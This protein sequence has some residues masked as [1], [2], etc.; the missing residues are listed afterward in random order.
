M[1]VSNR[2]DLASNART[3]LKKLIGRAHLL[4]LTLVARKALRAVKIIAPLAYQRLTYKSLGLVRMS[5]LKSYGDMRRNT[6][7]LAT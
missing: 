5:R 6:A 3:R 1:D 7:F 4:D 2:K